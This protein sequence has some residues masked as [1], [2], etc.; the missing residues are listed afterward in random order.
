MADHMPDDNVEAVDVSS[1]E[2]TAIET[3][4]T[5]VVNE[6]EVVTIPEYL[7]PLH[8]DWFGETSAPFIFRAVNLENWDICRRMLQAM[9]L[10]SSGGDTSTPASSNSSG[11]GTTTSGDLRMDLRYVDMYGYSAL[12]YACWWRSTPFDLIEQLVEYSPVEYPAI[13]NRKGRTPLHLAS[14]RGQDEV[15]ILLARRCPQAASVADKNL[16]SPLGDACSRNR[17]KSVLEALLEADRTQITKPNN[18]RRTPAHTFFRISHGYVTN[19]LLRRHNTISP[20]LSETEQQEEEGQRKMYIEKVKLVLEMERSQLQK[21]TLDLERD[22]ELLQAAI[23]SPS[24]SYP[25]VQYLFEKLSSEEIDIYRD[26]HTGETL[27]HKS[28]KSYPLFESEIFYKCD[29]CSHYDEI[30]AARHQNH[31][32]SPSLP[33]M[34]LRNTT[35]TDEKTG[36]HRIMYVNRDP[37]KAH[38]GVRCQTCKPTRQQLRVHYIP[39]PIGKHVNR[40]LLSK[41]PSCFLSCSTRRFVLFFFVIFYCNS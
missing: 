17:S 34:I 16:K 20:E 3:T 13:P 22:I 7:R 15:C 4:T 39:I 1:E 24:C 8:E 36:S 33:S 29:R 37:N 18:Q 5:A 19:Q 27:L 25:F 12:H 21:S 9:L 32:Q 30:A 11:N 41:C 40:N 10:T 35:T 6:D 28:L 38:W 26:P 31:D 14:W 2:G 23:E